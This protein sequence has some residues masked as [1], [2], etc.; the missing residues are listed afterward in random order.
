[1]RRALAILASTA[2]AY[3]PIPGLELSERGPMRAPAITSTL[4]QPGG[5]SGTRTIA[6]RFPSAFTYNPGFA[7]VG[8]TAQAEASESCG[9]ESRI[10][11]VFVRSSFGDATGPMHLTEDLRL[12]GFLGS[13]AGLVRQR[14]V[15]TI[16][17]GDDGSAEVVF[18][19][20]PDIPVTF[21]RIS[22]AGGSRGI[23]MTPARCGTYEVRAHFVSHRDEVSDHMLPVEIEG[24]PAP[25][26]I[27]AVRLD[28]RTLRWEVSGADHTEVRLLRK[29]RRAW[30]EV[31][32]WRR[33]ETALVL[34]SR[35]RGAFRAD[36]RAFSADG[37]ASPA[38][39]KRF[40]LAP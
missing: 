14:I 24:C 16:I 3:T 18:D 22:L 17:V 8:C 26:R 32:S 7:V 34:P 10:G 5:Q 11:E 4:T 40:R 31:R 35:L 30:R 38:R 6:A 29:A 1:M 39:S 13:Y 19:D 21:S 36:L 20:L 15:G 12:V 23:L 28:G 33:T 9:E 25:L 27:A 37:R 2:A